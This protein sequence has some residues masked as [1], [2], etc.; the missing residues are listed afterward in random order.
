MTGNWLECSS[1]TA[2]RTCWQK[3]VD[4][5]KIKIGTFYDVRVTRMGD[6]KVR[7]LCSVQRNEVEKS[8]VNEIRVLGNTVQAIQDVEL[9]KPVKIVL[10]KDARGSAQ[11]WVEITVDEIRVPELPVPPAATA[12]RGL[13]QKGGKN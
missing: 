11:R 12:E 5:E 10:Q 13:H 9:H 8:S 1:P 4:D 3:V 6:K 2:R 7:L